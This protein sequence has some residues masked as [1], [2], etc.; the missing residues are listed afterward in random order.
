VLTTERIVEAELVSEDEG[1]PI[2]LQGLDPST[3]RRVHRHGEK[4]KS[5]RFPSLRCYFRT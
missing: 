4:A 1:R 5:H 2:F 3:M